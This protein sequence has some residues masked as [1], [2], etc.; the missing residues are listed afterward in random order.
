MSTIAAVLC[1][2]CLTTR[3]WLQGEP[4][5]AAAGSCNRGCQSEEEEEDRPSVV[6]DRVDGV[7]PEKD[8]RVPV[9]LRQHA[10]MFF[11]HRGDGDFDAYL[12]LLQT[13]VT[14]GRTVRLTV[15][16]Y[17]GRILKVEWASSE[18]RQQPCP[19]TVARRRGDGVG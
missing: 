15:R 17:S 11:L 5:A 13:A 4:D 18:T 3:G 1:L 14:D 16:R 9:G 19:G 6:S 2:A 10:Q 8:G 12:R 7:Y